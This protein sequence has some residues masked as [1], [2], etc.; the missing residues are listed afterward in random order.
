MRPLH[1]RLA[2]YF[3][4]VLTDVEVAVVPAVGGDICGNIRA[5]AAKIGHENLFAEDVR[6]C[7]G[8]AT[9]KYVLLMAMDDVSMSALAENGDG[10]R[11]VLLSADVPGI[12]DD[13]YFEVAEAFGARFLAEGEHACGSDVC[14][15]A[16]QFKCITFRA[17]QHA[18]ATEECGHDVQ[19]TRMAVSGHA[20]RS[21]WEWRL[22]P[23][24]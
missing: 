12:A 23:R 10:E 3:P 11:I 5:A 21:R 7:C 8:G 14:H 18:P 2:P 19:D 15:V 17:A 16:R 9:G 22:N 1:H 4:A 13:S 6:E 24:R 20:L